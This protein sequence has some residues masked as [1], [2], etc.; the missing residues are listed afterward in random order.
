MRK[1]AC[2]IFGL[3]F[4]LNC[5]AVDVINYGRDKINQN[6]PDSV[7]FE[8]IEVRYDYDII[9]EDNTSRYARYGGKMY[10]RFYV[11]GL[12][13]LDLAKSKP[14]QKDTTFIVWSVHKL[15]ECNKGGQI[16]EREYDPVYEDTYFRF[17]GGDDNGIL[18]SDCLLLIS[19]TDYLKD[20]DKYTIIP[21]NMIHSK[22]ITIVKTDTNINI[23]NILNDFCH[24]SVY[25]ADGKLIYSH[26]SQNSEISIDIC[27]LTKGLN[28][29]CVQTKNQ[30]FT[31]KIIL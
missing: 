21:G 7:K 28:I 9:N 25:A 19:S 2:V 24:I 17:K 22:N 26:D 12:K 14:L 1:H 20:E 29:I 27:Y 6:I 15:Y 31:K 5:Y 13:Y 18:Y 23:L 8:L 4:L 30:L 16:I 11:E 3:F 10:L